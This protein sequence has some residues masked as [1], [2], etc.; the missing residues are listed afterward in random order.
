MCARVGAE[1]HDRWTEP[2]A[3]HNSAQAHE[4]RGADR[5]AVGEEKQVTIDDLRR[6]GALLKDM[7]DMDGGT[8]GGS[9][10]KLVHD[11]DGDEA[12]E[13]MQIDLPPRR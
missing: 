7:P 1:S 10:L 5:Q 6:A 8:Q 9:S 11:E 2:S 12:H 4:R 3:S 13:F